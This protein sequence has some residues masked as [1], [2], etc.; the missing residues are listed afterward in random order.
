MAKGGMNDWHPRRPAGRVLSQ[1]NSI[2]LHE[3]AQHMHTSI[4]KVFLLTILTL[5]D[6]LL[7]EICLCYPRANSVLYCTMICLCWLHLLKKHKW[8]NKTNTWSS[9]SNPCVAVASVGCT[10]SDQTQQGNKVAKYWHT[11]VLAHIGSRVDTGD[12]LRVQQ[13]FHFLGRIKTSK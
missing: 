5:W 2:T 13:M 6:T 4:S 12:N 11:L 7:K 1:I 3:C 9:W 8:R 10:K